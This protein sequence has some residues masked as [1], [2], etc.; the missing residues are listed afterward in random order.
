MSYARA[1]ED[2]RSRRAGMRVALICPTVGQ[3]RRGYERHFADLFRFARTQLDITLFKG[4][5]E[6]D[7]HTRVV[8][9]F[10]RTGVLGRICGSRFPYQRYR[11][12]FASFA[13]A[14]LPHL[15]RGKFD[16]AHFIDPP[17]GPHFARLRALAGFG[18][19]LLFT[20][21]G[22]LSYDA[23]RW[24]DHIHCITPMAMREAHRLN[25]PAGKVTM[26]PPGVDPESLRPSGARLDLRERYRVPRNE[27]VVLAIASMNRHHKRV[28]YLI[29]EMAR[30][31]APGLLWID[32]GMHPDGDPSLLELGRRLLGDRFRHTH[33]DSREIPDLLRLADVLVSAAVHESFGMAIAEAMA[34]GLPVIVHGSEHFRWLCGGQGHYADMEAAGALSGILRELRADPGRLRAPVN[35]QAIVDRFGWPEIARRNIEMYRALAS[36]R[37]GDPAIR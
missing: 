13:L 23:S 11:L 30:M 36:S 9:H 20:N 18:T 17:L 5:G 1:R 12:E 8:G 6:A 26:I 34:A 31:D 15:M 3:T 19:R 10:R 37:A 33:V 24:A 28:H 2:H 27:F 32:G 7:A 22:P 16:V 29:E 25:I 4:A 35:P 14:M 21:A